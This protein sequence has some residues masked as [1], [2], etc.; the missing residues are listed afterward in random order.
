MRGRSFAWASAA[1]SA[2][3]QKAPVMA[4]VASCWTR[5]RRFDVPMDPLLVSSK[6]LV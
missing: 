6:L 4:M 5:A 1:L 3:V 2:V